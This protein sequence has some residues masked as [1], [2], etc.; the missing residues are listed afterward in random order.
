MAC[1]ANARSVQCVESDPSVRICVI[2]SRYL[3]TDY[4]NNGDAHG[5][6]FSTF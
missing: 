4:V 5:L 6:E 2:D 3:I 1:D